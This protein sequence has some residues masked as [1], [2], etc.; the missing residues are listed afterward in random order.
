ML[1]GHAQH[2]AGAG[3]GV[4]ERA[5]HAGLGQRLVVLDEQQIH[6]EPD[7]FARGEVLAGGLVRQLGE[8][9][10]QLLEHRAHLR[11]ADGGGVEVDVG[12]LFGDEV[13]QPGLGRLVDL[14]VKLE[15]LEDVAHGGLGGFQHAVETAQ[16]GEREND[17]AVFGLL[18]IT[19]Q[20][21][22][23]GPDEG[24]EVGVGHARE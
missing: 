1:A 13:E 21:I 17:L 5:H 18:V 9:A 23:D 20:E 19:A 7:H 8:L 3:G 16:D 14:G 2:A 10:D 6:H 24:R 15:A 4:V 11:I 22:G 12:E